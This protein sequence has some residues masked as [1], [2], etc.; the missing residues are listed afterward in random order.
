[1]KSMAGSISAGA[2]LILLLAAENE[3]A[4][5]QTGLPTEPPFIA[6][7]V[8]T[9][10]S[11]RSGATESGGVITRDLCAVGPDTPGSST[12][13]GAFLAAD[14]ESGSRSGDGFGF[15]S[16]LHSSG[17]LSSTSITD[18]SN[19]QGAAS[20]Q[21]EVFFFDTLTFT[22]PTIPDGENVI[23]AFDFTLTGPGISVIEE[24]AE[25]TLG[26]VF[27][28]STIVDSSSQEATS[29]APTLFSVFDQSSN[30]VL[31]QGPNARYV[32]ETGGTLGMD[33]REIELGTPLEM[34]LILSTS[35]NSP[36]D[37][38]RASSD[39]E[40][41]ITDVRLFEDESMTSAISDGQVNSDLDT[42][43]PSLVLT[44]SVLV[45]MG[46]PGHDGTILGGSMVAGG[47]DFEFLGEVTQTG[48]FKGI[49]DLVDTSLG[50]T[51]IDFSTISE[52]MQVWDLQFTGDFEGLVQL[53]FGYDE[54][55]LAP[56]FNEADLKIVH[57]DPDAVIPAQTIDTD[58]NTITVLV[59]SFSPFVLGSTTV[60]PEP[61][62]IALMAIGVLVGAC[63]RSTRS[64]GTGASS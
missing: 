19:D 58:A 53:T 39:W 13:N 17:N 14:C 61:C 38:G 11:D 49:H 10:T 46:G 47:V 9:E 25:A 62:A 16:G 52:P 51:D 3:P 5:A 50:F 56:D 8:S 54:T 24:G 60:V 34:F 41:R 1:M 20:A 43:Y 7:D 23:V 37:T 30:Q 12:T 36:G 27:N 29:F 28:T 2:F 22:S 55:L 4:A 33:L 48:D 15:A 40:I 6:I 59:D 45:P 57:Y 64:T 21:S 32:P 31:F 18:S 63:S 42:S 35:A 26:I 44:D